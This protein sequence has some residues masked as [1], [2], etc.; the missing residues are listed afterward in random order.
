MNFRSNII[1]VKLKSDKV[2]IVLSEMIMIY[3]FADLKLLEFIETS[4]NNKG[5]CSMNTEGDY[6]ILAYPEKDKP[7]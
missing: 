7:G 5:L 6:T 3:N 1:S 4:E 2:I